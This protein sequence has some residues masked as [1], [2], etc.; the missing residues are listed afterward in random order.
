MKKYLFTFMVLLLAFSSV[1]SAKTTKTEPWVLHNELDVSSD[2]L[3]LVSGVMLESGMKYKIVVSGTYNA[4]DGI[5]ADAMCS[6]RTGSSTEWTDLVSNYESY[7]PDLL[8]LNVNGDSDWG[9]ECSD[10]HTYTMMLDGDDT[11]PEFY[12]YDTYPSNN[13]GN[14]QVK[15]YEFWKPQGNPAK[16][17]TS[18]QSGELLYSAG[19]YLA[20][21]PLMIG[22]DP[23]G[24]NYQGKLFSGS[25]ANAYLG[26]D[27]LPPYEG[28]DEA[29][30]AENPDAENHWTWPYRNDN[31][32][33]KWNDAWLDNKD[34]DG[35]GLLDRHFGYD[36]Y[37]GSGAWLTNHQSGEYLGDDE[38]TYK[39]NYFVKIVA[40]PS[41]AEAVEGV[42]YTADSKE[43]GPVI[44]GDFAK[45]MEV[46]N[47]QGT[48]D[49]GL[50]YK[51]ERPAL[52]GW[53]Y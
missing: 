44:W 16:A 38:E 1:V 25:Y 40:A 3:V 17:C 50:L 30:L 36:S 32:M 5:E 15:V 52:G 33:M 11:Q 7:G 46:Y 19:H 13:V 28:D 21:E 10:D 26:R 2:T 12:I 20:S 6:F 53:E 48:G 9:T 31:V 35:D 41:D 24:Y 45:I 34:C 18:I 37:R 14:L 29:Y 22:F 51:G 4:G 8:E 27:G 43:I 47:D 23:Y 49:H 42:W 39:W